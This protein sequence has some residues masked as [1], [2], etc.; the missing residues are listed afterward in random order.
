MKLSVIICTHNPHLEYLSR[1]LEA[2]RVQTL[3]MAEWELVLIDNASRSPIAASVSLTWHPNGRHVREEVL[4]LTPARLRGIQE[5]RGQVLVFVDDDGILEPSYLETAMRIGVSRPDLGCWGAG[6]IKP[7]YEKPPPEW[8][9]AWDEALAIRRLDRDL[10]ANIPGMNRSLP[11]GLGMCVRRTV[12]VRYSSL[13]RKDNIRRS[14]D[15]SGGSLASCGDTDIAMLACAL[16]MG[17]ASFTGLKITHLIPERRTTRQYM[18]RLIAARAESAVILLSLYEGANDG[19][20]IQ[21]L[22]LLTIKYF[23]HWIRYVASGSPV[24]FGLSLAH[25]K[26]ELD[27]CKRLLQSRQKIL[28]D[29]LDPGHGKEND[30]VSH[31]RHHAS[32]DSDTRDLSTADA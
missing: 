5:T 3:P 12:A 22:R 30:N 11:V 9:T 15:R 26:G 31:D 8:L 16:G 1:T 13:C 32:A 24:H 4:G 6:C 27:G 20:S 19:L 25:R 29:N 2:L 18:S 10:W 23:L 21:K 14:L 17:T 28:I 7:E